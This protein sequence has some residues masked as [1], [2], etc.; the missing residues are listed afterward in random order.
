MENYIIN[1]KLISLEKNKEFSFRIPVLIKPSECE[2]QIETSHFDLTEST[3]ITFILKAV[4]DNAEN[5]SHQISVNIDNSITK[6]SL[7]DLNME[8]LG[9]FLLIGCISGKNIQFSLS[10]T[11]DFARFMD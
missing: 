1:R 11:R 9:E 4:K 5:K 7:S 2:F 10:I 8:L 3:I 6:L